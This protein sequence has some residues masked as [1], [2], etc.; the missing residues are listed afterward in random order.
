MDLN[1]KR[2][3]NSRLQGFSNATNLV[4]FEQQAVAGLAL[5]CFSNAFRVGDSK[6]ISHHLNICAVSEI[7]PGLPIILVKGVFNRDHWRQKT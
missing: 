1:T 7:C 6:I 2:V 4:D 3:L 5:H